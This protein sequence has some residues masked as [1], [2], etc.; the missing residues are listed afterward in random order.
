VFLQ[1]DSEE[2][3]APEDPEDFRDHELIGLRVESVDG[4]ELGTVARIDHAAASDLL[5]LDKSGG[6]VAL[7]PFVN[8]LVPTVDV[9]NGKIVVDPPEGLLDL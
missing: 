4:V 1:P 7:I 6:G 2:L 5:V 3:D 9:A 8:Q